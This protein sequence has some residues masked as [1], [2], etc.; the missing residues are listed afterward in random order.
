MGQIQECRLGADL[1]D[2]AGDRLRPVEIRAS[3]LGD[4]DRVLR[5]VRN[6]DGVLNS[7]TTILP[8][9]I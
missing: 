9:S 7:E 5:E 2:Q 6:V 8:S 4:F 1:P 3:S